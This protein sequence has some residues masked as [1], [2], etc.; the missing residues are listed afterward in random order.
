M[1]ILVT[2]R[3]FGKDNPELFD[4]LRD[5]G[6][7]VIR[8]ETGGILSAD[9]MREM[10]AGCQG[11]IV[12][13]DPL[14]AEVLAAA[15]QLRAVAKYGVGLDNIDL[16]YCEQRGIAV[17]RTVGANSNAVADYAFAL[18]LAVAR[19]V[20]LIDRRCREK[21]WNKI[22]GSDVYGKTLGIVG[23]GAVGRCVARRARGFDMRILGYD[24]VW[25]DDWARE[26][27]VERADVNSICAEAD[28]IT[29]HT[30]LTYDTR[31][32]IGVQ[33]VAAMKKS[34]I[35]IN[36]ARG[37]LIDEAALLAAL[38]D[39][40]IYGAGIDAFARE[41]PTDAAWYKLNNL[42]MGSH[43]SASTTGSTEAMGRMATDNLLR[44]LHL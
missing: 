5:A 8:N 16:K 14:N 1:N 2:P 25:D 22:T 20:T 38:R 32:I 4:V 6:L 23:L 10:I 12:G 11:V 9:Q 29:L 7:T 37:G 41:P 26:A 33:Q 19:K 27:G 43:C 34:A 44:D 17:S 40:R 36:T 42:V 24:I 3:S 31:D 39:G 35:V 15:P 21:D 18:M 30:A 28:I 13:V